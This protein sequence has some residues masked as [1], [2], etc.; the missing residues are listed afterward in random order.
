MS[1]F[2]SLLLFIGH[3][4]A[5]DASSQKVKTFNPDSVSLKNLLDRASINSLAVQ[6]QISD[7]QAEEYLVHAST[8]WANPVVHVENQKGVDNTDSPINNLKIGASQA[9]PS[10]FTQGLKKEIAQMDLAISKHHLEDQLLHAQLNAYRWIYEYN[11]AREMIS[12]MERRIARLQMIRK[13]ISTRPY[14]SPQKR[15]EAFIVENKI[16]AIEKD[17]S[18]ARASEEFLWQRLNVLLKWENKK[19]FPNF[20]IAKNLPLNKGE[21]LDKALKNNHEIEFSQLELKK[22]QSQRKLESRQALP[23][24]M[25]SAAATRGRQGNP[26][27]NDTLGVSVSL[28][29]FNWNR[30]RT[31]AADS[32][33]ESAAKKEALTR[34]E[35]ALGFEKVYSQYLINQDYL[36]KYPI[37]MQKKLEDQMMKITENFKRSQV[38]LIT[39]FEV[40]MTHYE[41]L[42]QTYMIQAEYASNLADLSLLTGELFNY[43]GIL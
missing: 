29:L 2:L 27:N 5:A 20:W 26:E 3:S 8:A 18:S 12:L 6:A 10:P 16:V 36:L 32:H 33:V 13:Y 31:R 15:S 40:D 34:Q 25:L 21:L 1:L 23:D 39:Y 43:E 28:P 41:R 19:T 22:N 9:L 35:V 37:E 38:D 11:V 42:Q 14:L 7:V 17:L 30:N 4:F 24:V